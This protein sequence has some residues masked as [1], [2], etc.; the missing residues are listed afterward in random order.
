[1]ESNG[2]SSKQLWA[3][4][5]EEKQMNRSQ[6][7]DWVEHVRVGHVGKC[8]GGRENNQQ[9]EKVELTL[10]WW[11][12]DDDTDGNGYNSTNLDYFSNRKLTHERALATVASPLRH[13]MGCQV[14]WAT[15][16]HGNGETS[17]LKEK[18]KDVLET[19]LGVGANDANMEISDIQ[20]MK[21]SRH[22]N[23]NDTI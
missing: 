23:H 14:K 12:I 6:L 7:V 1:M 20:Q 8:N 16:K 13:D 4:H 17:D 11:V 5:D 3:W 21:G 19:T 18:G 22:D 10:R 15:A 2:V 9:A